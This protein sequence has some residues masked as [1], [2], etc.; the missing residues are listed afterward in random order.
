MYYSSAKL[1]LNICDSFNKRKMVNFLKQNNGNKMSVL[2]D[3]GAH[4]G[5]S[6][7][8]FNNVSIPLPSDKTPW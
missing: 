6:I 1:F 8:I 2:V 3:V 4:Y 5:E 7:K